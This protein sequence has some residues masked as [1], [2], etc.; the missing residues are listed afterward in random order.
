MKIKNIT[1]PIFIRE[2]HTTQI[3]WTSTGAL[4]THLFIDITEKIQI[5]MAEPSRHH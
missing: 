2:P 4:Q 5:T 1:T 3:N